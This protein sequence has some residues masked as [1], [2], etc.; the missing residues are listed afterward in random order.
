L[1]LRQ[2]IGVSFPL[3]SDEG[4]WAAIANAEGFFTLRGTSRT[5]QTGLTGLRTIVGVEK[6]WER[7]GMTLGYA[8]QQTF[9]DNRPDTVAH[10]PLIGIDISL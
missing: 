2:R 4:G 6:S 1:R 8:R 7:V 10:A 3:S 5:A 9:R